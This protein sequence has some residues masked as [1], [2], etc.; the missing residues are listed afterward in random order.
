MNDAPPICDSPPAHDAALDGVI[1]TLRPSYR[2]LKSIIDRF[3]AVLALLLLAPLLIGIAIRIRRDSP[4]PA[5]FN[6]YRAGLYG[7]PFK[8][9]KFRTM[10]IDADPY[11]DSPQSG[12]DPRITPLGR[13]LRET[14][15]DELPQLINVARGE[16]S[17][18]GPRPLYVQQIA[19]WSPRQRGR[20]LVKPG[21]TGLSQIQGRAAIPIE[22][23]LEIDVRYVEGISARLDLWI[24]LATVHAVRNSQ[25]IY[26]TRYSLQRARRSGH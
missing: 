16:M 17:L 26:E 19:E 23:K 20:L 14:S 13:W 9:L 25:D 11:G 10:R 24:L 1:C 2:L 5:L 18:V 4:G 12:H 22:E 3:V 15:L 7:R 6:Q 21:M 8:V